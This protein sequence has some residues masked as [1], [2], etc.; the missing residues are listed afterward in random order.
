MRI[1][2]WVG[3]ACLASMAVRP[4]VAAGLTL[5]V[6]QDPS[7]MV[8]LNNLQAGQTIL[9]D[10]V[11]SG[12]DVAGGQALASLE[13]TVVF[14]SAILGTPTV[15]SPGA[16]ITDAT[17]FRPTNGS[18]FADASYLSA[19]SDSNT[20]I[21]MNGTFFTF[22]V[23]VQPNVSGS[24]AL[25]FDPSQGGFVAA[26]DTDFNQLSIAAGPDLPFTVIGSSVPE[27]GMLSMMSIA[28]AAILGGCARS[29]RGKLSKGEP[30]VD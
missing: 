13:G 29:R 10:A 17:G 30:T 5:S 4:C 14:S 21:T 18:G 12:L 15:P 11:L 19:F 1:V 24:G 23:T 3:L 25:S 6:V 8:D 22:G 9:F 28:L 27:P 26:F 16:I 7:S 20:P 2:T